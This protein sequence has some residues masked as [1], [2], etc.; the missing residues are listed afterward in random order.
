MSYKTT[1]YS[2]MAKII[3]LLNVLFI[4]KTQCNLCLAI[5]E[6]R[7]CNHTLKL[8]TQNIL[9]N[10]NKVKNK[11][12]SAHNY[13]TEILFLVFLFKNFLVVLNFLV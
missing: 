6:H 9:K 1:R 4:F 2:F 13:I 3:E 5:V 10:K 12:V 8:E 7:I 11:Y